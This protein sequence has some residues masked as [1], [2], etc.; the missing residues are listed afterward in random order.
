MIRSQG[1]SGVMKYYAI[2]SCINDAEI[3]LAAAG[4]PTGCHSCVEEGGRMKKGVFFA[5]GIRSPKARRNEV[6]SASAVSVTSFKKLMKSVHHAK[7]TL[8]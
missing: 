1:V 5:S 6:T 8:S 2:A 4:A 7:P 3:I